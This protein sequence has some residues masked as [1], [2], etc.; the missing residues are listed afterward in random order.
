MDVSIR[1]PR[2]KNPALSALMM[3][4]LHTREGEVVNACPFGCE[5]DDLDEQGLCGH[6]VGYTNNSPAE[7][8]KGEGLME[9]LVWNGDRRQVSVKREKRKMPGTNGKEQTVF[10]PPQLERVKPTDV[11]VQITVSSRVYRNDDKPP[12]KKS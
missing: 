5:N 2:D 4:R 11:L 7:C 1:S 8:K 12:E 3:A 6:L 9:P 10:G